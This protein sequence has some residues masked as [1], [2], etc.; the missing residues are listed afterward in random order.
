[1]ARTQS[2][3]AAATA[4]SCS[5]RGLFDAS[6]FLAMRHPAALRGVGLVGRVHQKGVLFHASILLF[7]CP[8]RVHKRV[9]TMSA[10]LKTLHIKLTQG[11][12]AVVSES[13]YA[14]L[15][16]YKWH[17]VKCS[18][19]WYA[20]RGQKQGKKT[21]AVYMHRHLLRDELT[22]EQVVDHINGDSLD[23]SRPNLR[24]TSTAQN[25]L[26]SRR[27]PKSNCGARGVHLQRGA[28]VVRIAG[29]YGGTYDNLPEAAYYANLI[30]ERLS[31]GIGLRNE[32][33]LLALRTTLEARRD[34]IDSLIAQ[35]PMVV[36]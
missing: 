4:C 26:N 20:R 19:R 32:I 11:Q 33:D 29:E 13:D 34:L 3:L 18:G 15:S 28:F 22:D 6:P 31:P 2:L 7:I 8:N 25:N 36:A 1:M 12:V 16:S 23:N 27:V 5:G 21:I 24:A 10:E 35:L 30:L 14:E 9:Q 17:A